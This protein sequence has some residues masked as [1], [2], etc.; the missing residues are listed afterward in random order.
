MTYWWVNHKQTFKSEFEGNYIWSPKTKKDGSKNQA[1]INLTLAR[2]GDIIFSFADT[3]IK[4]VG[5]IAEQYINAP[6][7]KEF[8]AKGDQWNTDGYLVRVNWTKLDHPFKP[9]D[10]IDFLSP[11]LPKSYSPIQQNGNGN[12]GVYLAKISED[13]G[14][15]LLELINANNTFVL[16]ELE[17][18]EVSPEEKKEEADIMSSALSITEKEQLI[19]ARIG[20]GIF[21]SN[22][23]KIEKCCRLT[24]VSDVKFLIAS[25]IKPW[26][27]STN[28]EK[29]DGYNGLLLSP[30][31]DKLFDK[32]YISFTANGKLLIKAE[33]KAV[34]KGWNLKTDN[35]GPFHPQQEIYLAYHREKFN[36]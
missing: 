4:A 28:P 14:E 18:S 33:A 36:F 12:Q 32:G 16:P 35:V 9:K 25:H 23:R 27:K 17:D 30:H 7:P 24:G 8:G 5:T 29:L 10:N 19:K 34:I 26:S 31:V 11:Y 3:I 1:Y 21:K 15:K 13:F 20:Q 22:V 6:V 2:P